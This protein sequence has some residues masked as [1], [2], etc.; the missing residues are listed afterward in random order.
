LDPQTVT[1]TFHSNP[2]GLQV[3][4]NDSTQATPFDKTVIAGSS[5]SIT[6]VSPQ[7]SGSTYYFQSWSDGG[8]QTHTI[9]APVAAIYTASFSTAPVAAPAGFGKTSPSNN[10]LKQST[11][12]TLKWDSSKRATSYEYCVDTVNNNSCDTSWAVISP[13]SANLNGLANDMV[14]YWQVR[15]VNAGGTVE[16]NAGV[17]W[18]FRVK[19]APPTLVSPAPDAHVLALRPTFDWNDVTTATGYTIQISKNQT[20]TQVFINGYP[21]GSAYVPTVNLSKNTVL[22]WRVRVQGANGPSAFSPYRSFTTPV[23]PPATPSLLS[24]ASNALV[25]DY[26]P[27]F[28]WKAVAGAQSYIIQVDN[29]SNFSSPE[30]NASSSIAPTFTPTTDL[31]SNTKHYWR[32]RA[33]NSSGELSNWSGFHYFRAAILPPALLA[34][35]DNST[36]AS[37]KPVLDWENVPGN[38][39]YILEVWK[40]G[41]TPVLVK[42]ITLSK[43]VSQFSF[44]TNLLPTTAYFWKVRTLAANGPSAWSAPFDFVTVP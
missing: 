14:Y 17:W 21:K 10:A 13:T 38:S 11:H 25:K 7:T 20:F 27:I 37:R 32:V 8:P 9:L 40:A 22:Y 43:N 26:T 24:P 39:G 42:T 19:Y 4:V 33:V 30:V 1:L 28:T 6:A 3:T 41:T 5:N 15:A 2:S 31:A 34:P 12:P 16:A 44:V 29:N 18:K 36:T 35:T 23:N